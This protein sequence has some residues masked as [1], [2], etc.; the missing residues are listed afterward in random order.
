MSVNTKYSN[1]ISYMMDID[2]MVLEAEEE[3]RDL[4]DIEKE[5]MISLCL[6]LIDILAIERR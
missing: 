3:L 4:S 1:I 6:R 5:R 2:W